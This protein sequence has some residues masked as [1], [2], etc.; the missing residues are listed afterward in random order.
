VLRSLWRL[1]TRFVLPVCGRLVSPAWLE[2]G[3]FL[4]PSIERLHDE[5]PDLPALWQAAG[6]EDVRE[7]R[8]SFGAGVVI[9][10]ERGGGRAT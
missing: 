6:I 9:W 7:Q 1:D 4:G 2:V 10:G 8:L 5:E 3:Q